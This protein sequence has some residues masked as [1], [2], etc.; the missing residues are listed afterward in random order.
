M[1]AHW[2]ILVPRK[3]GKYFPIART[4]ISMEVLHGDPRPE[5]PT[6]ALSYCITFTDIEK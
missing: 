5:N 2:I 6:G 3:V 1:D 4:E